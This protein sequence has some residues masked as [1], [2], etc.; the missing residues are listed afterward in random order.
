MSLPRLRAAFPVLFLSL[1][2]CTAPARSQDVRFVSLRP[3]TAA[4]EWTAVVTGRGARNPA[5]VSFWADGQPVTAEAAEGG[6]VRLKG[7]PAGVARI[8]A[9][10]GKERAAAVNVGAD[11]PQSQPFDDWIVYQIMVD[12]FANGTT[13]N[14]GEVTGWK[15]PNYAGGDLQGILE[16]ADHLQ[17]LGINTVWLSPVFAARSSH[18]YDATNYYQIG[19]AV[20]L[21]NDPAASFALFQKLVKDLHGRGIRVMLDVALN[22]VSASYDR[23]AGDPDKLKPRNTTARQEAEKVWDSW[24]S[25]YRYWDFEHAPTRQFLKNVA[26]YWLTQGDVDGLRMD[27][28]RGVPHD[29]WAELYGDVKKAKP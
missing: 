26:L 22:H 20:A 4:G 2:A 7:V 12:M 18:G 17:S 13:A 15:H 25:N 1:L 14:D 5:A 24:G 8:E 6:A 10:T 29:F 11:S 28:V 9:G 19:G 27:Y 16:H 3:G 21:P 23:Q